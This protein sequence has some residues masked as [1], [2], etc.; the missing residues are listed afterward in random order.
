VLLVAKNKH[1]SNEQILGM[2]QELVQGIS[3]TDLTM[4]PMIFF[5]YQMHSIS[6]TEE[7]EKSLYTLK[8][9]FQLL[10]STFKNVE[11]LIYSIK[12]DDLIKKGHYVIQVIP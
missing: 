2:I 10:T 5:K 12:K 4:L 9:N 3:N 6:T 8:G 11:D 7:I 1:E